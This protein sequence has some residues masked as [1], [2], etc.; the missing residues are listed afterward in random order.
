MKFRILFQKG[1]KLKNSL[2]ILAGVVFFIFVTSCKK[3]EI[4]P[5]QACFSIPD[6]VLAG[7]EVTFE[8]NCSA[9][10]DSFLWK[11][12][13][14]SCYSGEIVH[15]TFLKTGDFKIILTA[16]ANGL[17]DSTVRNIHVLS[18]EAIKHEGLI[19]HDQVWFEGIHIITGD[20]FI[21][22]ATVT[23]SAGARIKFAGNTGIYCAASRTPNSAFIAEGTREKPI[24]FAAD[25]SINSLGSWNSIGFYEGTSPQSGF[26]FCKIY[27]GGGDNSQ[28]ATI[29]ID[30]SQIGIENSI[31]S[32]SK[33][34]GIEITGYGAFRIF[35]QNQIFGCKSN[36]IVLPVNAV[37]TLGSG[38][39]IQAEPGILVSG[40]HLDVARAVWQNQGSPFLINKTISVGSEN[41]T[42]LQINAGVKLKFARNA[43]L[44]V[45]GA[46][47]PGILITRGLPDDPVVLTSD[48]DPSIQD[49]GDWGHLIFN[50]GNGGQNKLSNS[51]IEYGG[52][53]ADTSGM[54]IVNNCS[55]SIDSC[56]IR[57][58]GN[59]GLLLNKHA[60]FTSFTHNTIT[61]CRN[62]P[63]SVSGNY[64]H[65]IG[66]DNSFLT[67]TGI[68]INGDT[69]THSDE[70]WYPQTCPYIIDGELIIGSAEGSRLTV[71]PGTNLFFTGNS[72][73]KVGYP[74]GNKGFFK[75]V[76]TAT[77][78]VIFTSLAPSDQQIPGQWQ[79][80]F[81]YVGTMNGSVIQNCIL[82]YGGG[83]SKD[84]G[85]ITCMDTPDSIPEIADNKIQY[86]ASWGIY[87]IGTAHPT[88]QQN[89]YFSNQ[90]GD[91]F[92]PTA[93]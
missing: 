29:V 70:T 93:Y 74:S 66:K 90:E 45:S 5:P 71:A 13:D 2:V 28:G 14:D 57:Y 32:G 92:E 55:V 53:Q 25:S 24:I 9:N 79:G 44:V 38:N 15:H 81:F 21:E 83:F 65:T 68:E 48:L 7:A 19:D 34:K 63:L 11:V 58:A 22:G 91:F 77:N 84:S 89:N 30:N 10:A 60:F 67:A 62:Y 6:E 33:K 51:I 43:G 23:V 54:I 86:S 46:Q 73:I 87:L 88:L 40:D 72:G 27:D 85:I 76:G 35:E 8:A 37:Y 36:P 61:K 47:T 82:T 49:Y 18:A 41:G 26:N 80:I 69:Y 16:T 4:Q 56:T 39:I 20:V 1:Y 52:G 12:S 3:D 42:T 50:S 59:K 78:P 75:A 64:A 17:C 31:I